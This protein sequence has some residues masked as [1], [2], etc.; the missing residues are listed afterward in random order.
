MAD[1]RWGADQ[2]GEAQAGGGDAVAHSLS[3][4]AGILAT[5]SARR[6]GPRHSIEASATIK[7]GAFGIGAGPGAIH[8]LRAAAQV[9]TTATA[10]ALQT[11]HDLEAS[12][13]IRSTTSPAPLKMQ[14]RLRAGATIRAA[15]SGWLSIQHPLKARARIRSTADA[16]G[17]SI[18]HH[19]GAIALI[20]TDSGAI[21][22]IEV[23]LILEPTAID[24][25][26]PA[27]VVPG[28]L[29]LIQNPIAAQGLQGW[30]ALGG[31]D[32]EIDTTFRWDGEQSVEVTPGG[33]GAGLQIST[34]RP[35]GLAIT[36]GAIVWGQAMLAL[37]LVLPDPDPAPEP[38]PED[39]TPPADPTPP[40]I[41]PMWVNGWVEV[42]YSDGSIDAGAEAGPF[43]IT[44]TGYHADWDIFLASFAPDADKVVVEARLIIVQDDT[45][46]EP[47]RF[48]VGGAQL[49]YDRWMLGP[50]PVRST[51]ALLQSQPRQEAV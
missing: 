28:A 6:L 40:D 13:T 8:P 47:T 1:G 32:L 22:T 33:P 20:V 25:T 11:T 35:L 16:T 31:A 17:I 18:G 37:N 43:A 36:G 4:R 5:A 24:R 26:D 46:S 14:H 42:Q 10:E 45:A 9:A 23:P 12:A 7:S 44:G 30:T 3:A 29:N 27:A 38:D 2:W 34:P 39:P 51:S 19:L 15:A 21:Y 48:W 49:E 50:Q 41:D